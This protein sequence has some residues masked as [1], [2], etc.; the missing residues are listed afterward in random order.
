MSIPYDQETLACV[1]A[2]FAAASRLLYCEPDDAEVAGQVEQRMFAEAPFG[3]DDAHV[4]AGLTAMDAWCDE[5]F[6]EERLAALKREWFRLFVGAGTPDAPSWESFYV[7]PNSQLF[8]K[9]TLEV[10]AW[11][12]RYGLKIERLHAEPDDHLGLM[13]G[14]V[15][16]LIGLEAEA[17]AE[18]DERRAAE[19]AHDQEA[20][21]VE[22]VLPW[23]AAWRYS[24]N[25]RAASN[26]F[27]GAGDFVFG[28]CACYARRFD[29]AFDEDG[30]VFKRMGG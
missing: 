21:L 8:S 25:E 9:H 18:N 27:R 12:Q 29:V 5:P 22:H 1:E 17:R 4:R 10:R 7:D 23:L 15:G 26:Y 13:L 24:V 20:F 3:M 2:C 16:H 14:F 30:Q 28:L 11:Y 19:L 6:D